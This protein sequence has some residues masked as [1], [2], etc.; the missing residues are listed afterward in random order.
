MLAQHHPGVVLAV[1]D[2]GIVQAAVARSGIHGQILEVEPT[3]HLGHDVAGPF[4]RGLVDVG[5]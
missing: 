1:I 2:D 3:Y 4:H 5:G